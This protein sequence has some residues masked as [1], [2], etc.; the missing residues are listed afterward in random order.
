MADPIG[1]SLK[2]LEILCCAKMA[3]K[4]RVPTAPTDIDLH[5]IEKVVGF[6]ERYGGS[7]KSIA[8]YAKEL[9]KLIGPSPDKQ[10]A[11]AS[12]C[13]VLDSLSA[14]EK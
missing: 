6:G 1:I 4:T 9:D 10:D 11:V 5:E 2:D 8:E 7:A 12:T 13:F 14:L 3:D